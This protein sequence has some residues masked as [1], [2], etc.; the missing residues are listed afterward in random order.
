MY[1]ILVVD[2][3]QT[4]AD[5]VTAAMGANYQVTRASSL[6]EAEKAVGAGKFD[7][8]LLDV[9]LPDGDGYKFCAQLRN[10]SATQNVPIIFLTGK[11]EISDKVMGFSLG[12]D[13]YITKPFSMEELRVRVDARLRRIKDIKEGEGNF[14]KGDLKLNVESQ[15][16]Y[17]VA[18]SHETQL[19]LTPIEFKLLLYLARNEEQ[20]FDRDHLIHKVWGSE[21]HVSRRAIDSHI[22]NLRK[23]IAGSSYTIGSVHGVG[24]KFT[25]RQAETGL[26]VAAK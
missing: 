1:R 22:S 17:L 16:V 5:M 19:D 15:R 12:A 10:A 23:K 4:V 18:G 25:L 8:I 3:N 9:G 2:D 13:D 7:L 14:V 20:V 24:Y 6:G 26:K 11:L 21:I